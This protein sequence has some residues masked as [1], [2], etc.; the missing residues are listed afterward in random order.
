MAKL[1]K[2]QITKELAEKGFKPVDIENYDNLK[3]PIIIECEN[4]HHLRV[5]MHKFR[6]G[7]FRCPIC[8]GGDVHIQN[9]NDPPKK[10]AGATRVIALDNASKAMG[11]S[12]FE[13]NELIFYTL[14][15]FKGDFYDRITDAFLFIY[16]K[17][18]KE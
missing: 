2:D 9:K 13:D 3:S 6:K 14:I 16:N 15:N 18:V 5:N 11:L 12:I 8:S 1:S 10:E 17:V 4:G 7:S